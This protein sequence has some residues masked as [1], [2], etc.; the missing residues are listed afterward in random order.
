MKRIATIVLASFL[1]AGGAN[2]AE[3]LVVGIITPNTGP[4]ATVGVRQLSAVQWWQHDVNSKG[5]IRGRQVEI[6]TCDD[7]ANPERAVS[8]TRDLIGKGVS[9]IINGS[10]T[11]A[12]RATIP[13]IKD[14]PVMLIA[15][16][17]IVPDPSTFAFQATP[18]DLEVTRALL[19]FLEANKVKRLAMIA[20]TDAT[21]EVG[22]A[23]A[24]Q[25]FPPAGIELALTRI[26]L[27][28]NDASI[29]LANV[30]K[31]NPQ[32]L[33]SSYSGAGAATVVKSYTN[34][35]LTVPLIVSNANV[36]DAF[37]AVVK[38]D[39]P[40]QLRGMGLLTVAPDLLKD[41]VNKARIEYFDKSYAAW[42]GERADQLNQLGLL[43]ADT[44]DAVLR[45]VDNPND[46][47]AVR[48][49]LEHTPIKSALTLNFSPDSHIGLKADSM[50][51]VQYKDGRWT[52][53]D[54]L[55]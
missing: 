42:K 13:L 46:P 37:I 12:V 34:L 25:V 6:E 23:D 33:Y 39:M 51:V 40:P 41:P 8:C 22:V 26:D 29:Q 11:G 4:V 28:A 30:V 45:G 27:R 36:S 52:K 9:V 17:A 38:D 50:A 20:A 53:A 24:Q 19:A 32:A 31:N 3:P 21:G 5:G 43:L 16:P 47:K 44:A 35:G 2:A 7:Q 14:G 10:L 18:T 55:K 48:S 49:F 15:S 1:L 54:P